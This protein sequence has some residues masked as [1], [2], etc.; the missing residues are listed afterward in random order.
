LLIAGCGP[1]EA[2]E[3]DAA[4][5]WN[6]SLRA[7]QVSEAAYGDEDGRPGA[8]RRVAVLEAEVV[9]AGGSPS[10][11]PSASGATGGKV[12]LAAERAALRT[13]VAAVGLLTDAH[14]REVLAQVIAQ[15]AAAESEI[16]FALA[17]NPSP[18][19]FPGQPL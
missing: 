1:P 19:S 8:K 10:V 18:S 4:E 5:V 7:A 3:V 16:L 6:D 2:T 11:A 12:A 13:H 17:E 9:R 14:S 15:T